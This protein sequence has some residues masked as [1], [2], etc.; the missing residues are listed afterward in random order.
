MAFQPGAELVDMSII[1]S[2]LVF[3]TREE[4]GPTPSGQTPNNPEAPPPE[5]GGDKGQGRNK[6]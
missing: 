1:I 5:R 3:T 4:E 6:G 2:P